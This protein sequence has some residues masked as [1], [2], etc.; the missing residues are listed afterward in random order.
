MFVQEV[1]QLPCSYN[2]D[3]KIEID[4]LT[5]Q[6]KST[7]FTK[8]PTNYQKAINA[9]SFQ[10]CRANPSLLLQTKGKLLE[11]AK[12]KIHEDGY[13]YKKGRS[14]SLKLEP[15]AVVEDEPRSKR[16]KINAAT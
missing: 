16:Q 9:A 6:D 12:Q 14:R 13:C 4:E 5:V 3:G 15:S 2:D 10:L 11:L 8:N 1:L 7:I